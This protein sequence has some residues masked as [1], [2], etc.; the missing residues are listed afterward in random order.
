M[1]QEMLILQDI[2]LI[3]MMGILEQQQQQQQKQTLVIDS[4]LK[5]K[6]NGGECSI[7]CQNEWIEE[8]ISWELDFQVFR[9]LLLDLITHKVFVKYQN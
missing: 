7:V 2:I 5:W 1:S 4:V 8:N 3:Q 9:V 6:W